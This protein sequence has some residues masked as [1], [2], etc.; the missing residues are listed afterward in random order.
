MKFKKVIAIILILL[1]ALSLVFL[2]S[3]FTAR[4]RSLGIMKIYDRYQDHHGIPNKEGISLHLPYAEMDFYPLLVTYNDGI[5][6]SN[7]LGKPVDFTVEYTFA[8][9]PRFNSHSAIYEEAHPF[10]N[11]YLGVYYVKGCNGMLTQEDALNV[12][13]YDIKHL[14]LPAVGLNSLNAVFKVDEINST[15]KKIEFSQRDWILYTSEI[16]TNSI[17]HSKGNFFPGDLQFGKSPKTKA[18]Y[19]LVQMEGRLYLTYLEKEDINLCLYM[20]VKHPK[21]ADLIHE[22]IILKTRIELKKRP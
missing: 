4:A 8:D 18:D 22:E 1:L 20:M 12:V 11:A 9:F 13:S 3:P 15:S 14:A 16:I 21:T 5:G 19:P 7:F 6:L 2:L 17:I 10:Y